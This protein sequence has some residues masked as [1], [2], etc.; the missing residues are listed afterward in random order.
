MRRTDRSY[1]EHTDSWGSGRPLAD[2]SDKERHREIRE[3]ITE[4]P[5]AYREN[6]NPYLLKNVDGDDA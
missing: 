4:N 5:T 2:L 6:F 1:S 3:R